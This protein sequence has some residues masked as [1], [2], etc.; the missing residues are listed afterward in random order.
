MSKL[1]SHSLSVTRIKT[2]WQPY[3]QLVE[4]HTSNLL[5]PYTPGTQTQPILGT[6][7][8]AVAVLHSYSEYE[9]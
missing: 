2:P 9:K 1:P 4:I 5:T 8:T 6:D 7:I 3:S